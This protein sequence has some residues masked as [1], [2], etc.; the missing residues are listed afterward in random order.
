[1]IGCS[2][3]LGGIRKFE[4]VNFRIL[5]ERNHPKCDS[6]T[7]YSVS[8]LGPRT[9]LCGTSNNK[10]DKSGASEV[11]SQMITQPNSEQFQNISNMCCDQYLN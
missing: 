10:D 8:K 4:K 6:G 5:T 7:P 1:M 11:A 2:E 3:N 9:D